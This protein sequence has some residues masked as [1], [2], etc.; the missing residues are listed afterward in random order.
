MTVVVRELGSKVELLGLLTRRLEVEV[1]D[2]PAT[3]TMEDGRPMALAPYWWWAEGKQRGCQEQ[4]GGY[5]F[6]CI[7]ALRAACWDQSLLLAGLGD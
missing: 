4:A 6:V 2:S 1:M 7:R 5:A 3:V